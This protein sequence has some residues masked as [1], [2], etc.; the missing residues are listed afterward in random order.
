[1]TYKQRETEKYRGRE[2]EKERDRE[3]KKGMR[4][5]RRRKNIYTPHKTIKRRCKE[6]NVVDRKKKLYINKRQRIKRENAREKEINS[7]V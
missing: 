3:K 2:T 5:K 6:R 7:C 1:M 4:K